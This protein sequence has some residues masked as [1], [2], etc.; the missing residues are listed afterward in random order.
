MNPAIITLKLTTQIL[1]LVT[2]LVA[3]CATRAPTKF[4]LDRRAG[5]IP[6]ADG[7]KKIAE[8]RDVRSLATSTKDPAMPHRTSPRVEKIWVYDQELG[9]NTWMQGT[10]IF[11]EVEPGRWSTE[12]RAEVSP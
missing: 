5:L 4:E 6:E 10:F 7:Q 11:L 3:G 2:I 12:G 1:A 9:P 8:A